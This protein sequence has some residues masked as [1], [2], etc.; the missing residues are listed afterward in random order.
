MTSIALLVSACADPLAGVPRISDVDLADTDPAASAIATD[1]EVAR[2][3]FFGSEAATGAQDPA[4]AAP[5]A[6][7]TRRG[8][9]LDLFRYRAN[10]PASGGADDPLSQDAFAAAKAAENNA[11]AAPT[12]RAAPAS[13]A[14]PAPARKAGFFGRLT[15]RPSA[16]EKPRSGIDAMEVSFGEVLPYGLIARSCGAKGKSM[17]RKV[18]NA[19]ASGFELYDSNPS[20]TG[21]RTFYITGFKDGCPRQLTAAQVLLGA[22]SLYEQ[23]H[24]G[25]GGEFLPVGATDSAYEKVKGQVCGVR[26]G[27]PC[28][29]KMRRLERSTFFVNAYASPTANNSWSELLIH[30]G[31]VVAS[32]I[33]KSS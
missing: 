22:P 21:A 20:A 26:K 6:A 12:E 3:G 27:K 11:A 8:G 31:V 7:P 18:E 4:V 28:G 2:E 30:E 1:S 14:A 25:P 33:K 24:Y 19:S 5:T 23:L 13:E 15:A 17:G 29:S 9:V 32:S 16:E 10:T